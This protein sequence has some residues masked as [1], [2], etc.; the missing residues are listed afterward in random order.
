[1]KLWR[2][3]ADGNVNSTDFIIDMSIC[4]AGTFELLRLSTTILTINNVHGLFVCLFICF[5]NRSF[6][7]NYCQPRIWILIMLVRLLAVQK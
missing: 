2:H 7:E 5:Y 1:M 6:R 4:N 3:Y